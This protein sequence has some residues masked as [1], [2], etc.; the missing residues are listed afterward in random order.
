MRQLMHASL[1][2]RT[3]GFPAVWLH[4]HGHGPLGPGSHLHERSRA[5][6]RPRGWGFGAEQGGGANVARE[7]ERA[8]KR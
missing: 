2:A 7:M 5:C 6:E 1:T 8:M 3:G 4:P